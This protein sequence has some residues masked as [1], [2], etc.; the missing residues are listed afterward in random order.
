MSLFGRKSTMPAAED[1]LPGRTEQMPVPERHFVLGTPLEPPFPEGSRRRCSG[2]AASGARSASSG[3]PTA[4]T[5][6]RS[7]TPAASRRTRRTKRCAAGAPATPRS[8]SSCSTRPDELRRDAAVFWENHDPTQGMRQGND[9]GTQYRSGI[10]CF[11]RRAARRGRSVTRHVPGGADRGAATATIT[12]E[13]VR[14][15]ALLLRRG[16]PPAVPGQEPGR[17]LRPGRHRGRCPVGVATDGLSDQGDR[18]DAR[19][20]VPRPAH[21][22]HR[23]RARSATKPTLRDGRAGD[24]GVARARR[25]RAPER[26]LHDIV[27]GNL[28][29]VATDAWTRRRSR[30]GATGRSTGCSTSG[31]EQ[32]TAVEADD[33][34][35][36]RP[37]RL[38]H[39]PVRRR[40]ARAGHPGALGTFRVGAT[41]IRSSRSSAHSRPGRRA[42]RRRGR[43]L[44]PLR[45]RR[46]RAGG[47]YRRPHD[48]AAHVV[49]RGVP[50]G[51]RPPEPAQTARLRL[52]S[53]AAPDQHGH[54]DLPS[55]PTDLVE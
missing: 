35:H 28:D 33:P 42:G 21:A 17:L 39:L 5:R 9:V 20:A 16:L 7:A 45:A 12:T 18:I 4:C 36:P 23:A 46:R 54:H 29:G 6:P 27:N 11:S 47:G 51:D 32:G 44:D 41:A 14:G 48:D 34:Q 24:A 13:I 31:S 25:P 15:R 55:A 26:R 1:A 22:R 53:R 3:R 49:L 19:R 37:A 8:C 2:W 30:R 40:D 10:Y 50:R 52:G 38:E 43:R